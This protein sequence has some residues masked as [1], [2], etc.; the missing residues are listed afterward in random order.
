MSDVFG[1][2]F[3]FSFPIANI[4]PLWVPECSHESKMV[5]VSYLKKFKKNPI[6]QQESCFD[7]FSEY[8]AFGLVSLMIYLELT[9]CSPPSGVHLLPRSKHSWHI[10]RCI[11]IPL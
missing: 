11:T 7:L 4:N 2:L 1:V 3:F 9:I 5:T 6:P 10:R 8:F